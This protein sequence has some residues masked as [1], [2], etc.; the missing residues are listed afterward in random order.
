MLRIVLA[1][2]VAV[3]LAGCATRERFVLSVEQQQ[4]AVDDAESVVSAI[5]ERDGGHVSFVTMPFE[6]RAATCRVTRNPKIAICRYQL[7]AQELPVSGA[8]LG[9]WRTR[10]QV[11]YRDEDG[12]WRL[13]WVTDP[14]GKPGP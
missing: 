11:Y 12:Q 9:P 7:R 14:P 13:P 8:P 2:A 6:Q 4:K 1:F 3:A 5:M 10:T